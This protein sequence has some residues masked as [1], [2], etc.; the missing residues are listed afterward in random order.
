MRF[1]FTTEGTR[2]DVLPLLAAADKLIEQGHSVRL[3]ADQDFRAPATRMGLGF[4]ALTM[5]EYPE[6]PSTEAEREAAW[7]RHTRLRFEAEME[8]LLPLAQ[9]ADVVVVG[10][11][12]MA[13]RSAAE[14]AGIPCRVVLYS[15]FNIP[16]VEHSPFDASSPDMSNEDNWRLWM[17]S[18]T[19][20]AEMLA[21][22]QPAR[23]RFGLPETSD[24]WA[25]FLDYGGRPILA[26]DPALAPLP[27]DAPPGVVEVGAVLPDLGAGLSER[28]LAFLDEGDPPVFISFGVMTHTQERTRQVMRALD[29]LSRRTIISNRF[30]SEAPDGCLIVGP[31]PYAQL[32]PRCAAV[33]HHG[34]AGTTTTAARAGIP[35]AVAW[36]MGDQRYWGE[37]IRVLGIGPPPMDAERLDDRGLASTI[38]ELVECA[39][40]RRSAALLVS[41]LA[42]EDGGRRLAEALADT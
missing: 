3:V 6:P 1:L 12:S 7:A 9:D 4:A 10:F 14:A 38:E 11:I 41:Q 42:P 13:A 5:P 20:G 34:G 24:P 19:A 22:L 18:R 21:V 15:P 37:R 32:F 40:Y 33:V 25:H 2:G 16:S 28:T 36:H 8:Q 23:S 26:A 27:H 29:R 17:Q 30:A 39:E 35:Q 31:E